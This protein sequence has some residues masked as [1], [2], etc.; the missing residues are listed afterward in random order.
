MSS[1][2]HH[3]SP[4]SDVARSI[5]FEINPAFLIDTVSIPTDAITPPV[6]FNYDFKRE[7]EAV[8]RYKEEQENIE[9]NDDKNSSLNAVDI[10]SKLSYLPISSKP[11]VQKQQQEIQG[12]PSSSQNQNVE[13]P[14]E[15]PLYLQKPNAEKPSCSTNIP[16]TS[17]ALTSIPGNTSYAAGLLPTWTPP[18]LTLDDFFK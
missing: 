10:I 2:T 4:L 6:E 14:P 13:K 3:E 17:V 7:Y 8:T 9:G 15:L 1:H 16:E 11:K 5:P 12:E 18:Q